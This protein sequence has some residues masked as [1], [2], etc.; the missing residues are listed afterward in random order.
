[1]GELAMQ[2]K[3]LLK[4]KAIVLPERFDPGMIKAIKPGD[5]AL[6]AGNAGKLAMAL[7]RPASQLAIHIDTVSTVSQAF[8]L[9]ID[10]V[11]QA[12]VNGW[13]KWVSS[14]S[15]AGVIINATAGI[16]PPGGMVGGPFMQGGLMQLEVPPS[17]SL[18]TGKLY[19]SAILTVLGTAFQAWATG[20]AHP[21]LVFPGGAMCVGSMPPSPCAPGVLAA[22]MS[23]GETLLSAP[24]LKGQMLAMASGNHA[25]ALFDAFAQAFV[26]LFQ[27]WKG[28][29]QIMAI[30][31]A[32]GVASPLGS[33]VAGAV[34]SG[35]R[36]LGAPLT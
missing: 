9:L 34:G 30:L 35:G 18:P 26:A 19:A 1:M 21:A 3:T 33:P 10:Q 6:Q 15:F 29:T 7:F 36:L 11:S 20:Y 32:G 13:N 5:P 16:L 4:A 28:S 24:L 14:V 27:R 17:P 12:L 22:G 2:V 25:E 31:G 8:S 23:P